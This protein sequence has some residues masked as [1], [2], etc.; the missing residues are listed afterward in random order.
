PTPAPAGPIAAYNFN[1][2]DG[3]TVP[4]VSGHGITGTIHGTVSTT[5]MPGHG[6]AFIFNGTSSY[7]DLGNPALLQMTGSMTLSAWMNAA[8]NPS[9]DGNVISKSNSSSGWQLKTTPDTGPQTF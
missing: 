7:V 8:A 4:D 9:N 3:T 2:S 1:T 5:G 6:N